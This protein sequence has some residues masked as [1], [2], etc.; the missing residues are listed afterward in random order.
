MAG[1][2]AGGVVYAENGWDLVEGAGLGAEVGGAW[3]KGWGLVKGRG[4]KGRRA[5]GCRVE[6]T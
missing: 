6:E 1:R 5:P 2:N 4:S 3:A